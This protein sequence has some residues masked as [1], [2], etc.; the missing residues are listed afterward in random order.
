[1][2]TIYVTAAGDMWREAM[3]GTVAILGSGSFDR[4][5][6]IAGVFSVISVLMFWL[7]GRDFTAFIK[8]LA[9][10]FIIT[11]IC[12]VPKRPVQIIDLSN[13]AAVYEV[14][15]VPVVLGFISSFATT[16]GYAVASK[17]D[18][19]ISLPDAL[20][21]SKT[22]MAFGADLVVAQRDVPSYS[23]PVSD[24]LLAY[25]NKCAVPAILIN[26]QYHVHDILEAQD[27]S[28][29][30]FQNPSQIASMPYTDNSGNVTIITCFAAAAQI[31]KALNSPL[32]TFQK[33]LKSWTQR[34]FGNN[35]TASNQMNDYIQ[36]SSQFFYGVGKSQTD[37][38]KKRIL[39]TAVNRSVGTLAAEDR[40]DSLAEIIAEQQ[41][42]MKTN[43]QGKVEQHIGA[44]YMPLLHSV[45][46]LILVCI[47]PL[48]IAISLV[49]HETFGLKTIMTYAGGWLYL[50]MWP[51]MF[52]LVNF[53]AMYSLKGH[54]VALSGG[55]SL[56][57]RYEIAGYY[58]D[59][60][61]VAGY[62]CLGAIPVLSYLITRGAAA[63]GSQ[64]V[65][66][67]TGGA[68][69]A[70][71]ASASLA[72]DGNWSFNNLSQDNVSANK[73]N[74]NADHREGMTTTQMS[75]GALTSTT[76]DGSHVLDGTGAVSKLA[77]NVN[78][79]SNMSDSL[80]QG[81]RQASTQAS[82]HL[83]GF[84]HATD[85]AYSQM[86]D[87]SHGTSRSNTTSHGS[88][89]SDSVSQS[90]T[91]SHVMDMAHNYAQRWG[92]SDKEAFN[93]MYSQADSDNYHAETGF[94]ASAGLEVAGNG[95][96]VKAGAGV[97]AGRTYGETG[98][99]T[100]GSDRSSD[101]TQDMSATD[102]K[103]FRESLDTLKQSRDYSG[104]NTAEAQ[105]DGRSNR[106]ESSLRT[107]DS[108]YSQYTTSQMKANEMSQQAQRAQTDSAGF[109]ANMNQEFVNWARERGATDEQLTNVSQQ[110][111]LA[112]EFV[113]ERFG[114]N[115]EVG[116]EQ[117]MQQAMGQPVGKA[118]PTGGSNLGENFGTSGNAN[119]PSGRSE[120]PAEG[121]RQGQ[122]G[123]SVNQPQAHGITS[124]ASEPQGVSQHNAQEPSGRSEFP[125]EGSRQGQNFSDNNAR[126]NAAAQGH[127]IPEMVS[128]PKPLSTA[129]SDTVGAQKKEI[130]KQQEMLKNS[131]EIRQHG[132][133]DQ[134]ENNKQANKEPTIN[135]P[136][137]NTKEVLEN[138]KRYSGY[139]R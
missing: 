121:S 100:K 6:R 32:V 79:A 76:A 3:N 108:E 123:G 116:H 27:I 2:F 58:T 126:L 53:V 93:R 68:A 59:I 105:T 115:M 89:A 130:E 80:T 137:M 134:L 91:A 74:T 24:N 131:G 35:S 106:L 45:L 18:E 17:F 44:R 107:A 4:L 42:A 31:Q 95:G 46:E 41:T 125:A 136:A 60:A 87:M 10:F 8:W 64:V 86:N 102:R 70:S 38:L 135:L 43:I 129:P 39:Q 16:V 22:G 69:L 23:F 139:R 33:E 29:V 12:L 9:V 85:T 122:H 112:A 119:M 40:N 117:N 104:G 75:N 88:E 124:A 15:N 47:F 81:A 132:F 103:D 66:A 56:S 101:H 99:T 62:L 133:G 25:M 55:D 37:I 94:Q 120:F 36:D 20:Q 78:F 61:A 118:F 77:T 138:A 57:A 109:N 72:E 96:T 114:Q 50:Q 13:Q 92:V 98:I 90:Q 82:S 21:Y 49:S 65:G 83:Q 1:M 127:E 30:I 26:N 14:D 97:S 111:P 63:V 54:T 73:W 113:R 7:K 48:V 5:I 71:G 11:I 19:D 110:T 84:N 52:S 67:V 128:E 34:V 51:I 28:Q